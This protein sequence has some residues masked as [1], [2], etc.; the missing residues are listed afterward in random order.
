MRRLSFA[1]CTFL[2]YALGAATSAAAQPQTVVPGAIWNDTD[3]KLIQAHGG[4]MIQVGNTFYWFG[5]DHTTGLQFKNVPCYASTDLVHWTGRGVVLSGKSQTRTGDLGPDRVLERP[6]VLYNAATRNY[7]MYM[8][9]DSSNYREAKV[10]VATSPTVDGAYTY[11]GSFRPMEHQSRD[12]T[13]FQDKD[14][15]GY[16]IFEDRAS[17]VR[18]EQLAPDY[19]SV[20]REVALIPHNY[21][22]PAMLHVGDTY[23]LLGSRLSGWNANPNSYATAP[24][25]AGPWSE[26]KDVAPPST[27]TYDSQ[28]AFLLPVHGSKATTYVYIGDRWNNGKDLQN[29]RYIWMPVTLG[30]HT[31]SLAPDV[32]WTIDTKTGLAATLPWTLPVAPGAYRLESRRGGVV[33]NP[34]GTWEL[35]PVGRGTYRITDTVEGKAL[36][37]SG[38]STTAGAPVILYAFGG[39]AN[40]LW[41]FTPASPGYFYV[42]NK[43]SG[44]R[45][46]RQAGVLVQRPADVAADQEWKPAK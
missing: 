44:Q 14:G 37:V 32:P 10:G 24:A 39:G 46:T 1:F 40:Q 7:V 23:F 30:D 27:N 12:M 5:E 8:H 16:L 36:D 9:I 33:E 42:T 18:I 25:L 43:H 13:L 11:R 21:E 4:G 28:S 34:A 22:G 41:S 2:A 17:G 38:A 20:S 35:A 26:W 31:M 29:A 15:A 45:L 3:G 19:L 6:K